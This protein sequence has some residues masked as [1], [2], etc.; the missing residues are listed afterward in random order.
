MSSIDRISINRPEPDNFLAQ[1]R[2]R[3]LARQHQLESRETRRLVLPSIEAQSR[4]A[5]KR[6]LDGKRQPGDLAASGSAERQDSAYC[7]EEDLLGLA[8]DI[9]GGADEVAR[10]AASDSLTPRFLSRQRASGAKDASAQPAIDRKN[11]AQAA[12]LANTLQHEEAS[13]TAEAARS[14]KAG[15]DEATAL[16]E[17]Q[18]S[19][20]SV[21][22]QKLNAAFAAASSV[23]SGAGTH[24]LEDIVEQ[25]LHEVQTRA[26]QSEALPADLKAA[27][28]ALAS[29][30]MTSSITDPGAEHLSRLQGSFR[31]LDAFVETMGSTAATERDAA[32][33]H[34]NGLYTS[35]MSNAT[36][37]AQALAKD[38]ADAPDRKSQDEAASPARD[39]QTLYEFLELL[40]SVATSSAPV[41][42]QQLAQARQ[43]NPEK[44]LLRLAASG[45]Q[46]VALYTPEISRRFELISARIERDGRKSARAGM[47]ADAVATEKQWM[48]S[49]IK[50]AESI[51]G[52]RA[53]AQRAAREEHEKNLGVTLP[54]L[55]LQ[56]T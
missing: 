27:L 33:A 4:L 6:A 19:T 17:E 39:R 7:L 41:A 34:G 35:D 5:A 37:T 14:L 10:D 24:A 31:F 54:Q 43:T 16:A 32:M 48:Q 18:A 21:W 47:L 53:L 52:Y 56:K 36:K 46:A 26:A 25:L 9:A 44:A 51:V 50:E 13:E 11:A 22:L 8:I 40:T 15:N 30:R 2:R 42:L 23:T 1:E 29:K 12:L 55:I 38:A 49:V 45:D 20:G 28:D 3:Q